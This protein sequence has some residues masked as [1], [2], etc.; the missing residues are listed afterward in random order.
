[1]YRTNFALDLLAGFPIELVAVAAWRP[2][3]KYT[4]PIYVIWCV[5]TVFSNLNI[6]HLLSCLTMEYWHFLL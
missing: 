1:M 4:L 5:D 3:S 2:I 6:M